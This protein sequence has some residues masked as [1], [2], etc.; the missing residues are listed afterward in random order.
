MEGPVPSR[1]RS[2][3]A[4]LIG[5]RPLA[6][7]AGRL[8]LAL[9]GQARRP[10][11]YLEGGVPDTVEG[12]YELLVLHAWLVI[13]RLAAAGGQGAALAQA[14]FDHMFADIDRALRELGVGDLGVGR[15]VR[16]MAEGFYGR[17]AAYRAA[18]AA[19]PDAADLELALHR[20]LYGGAEPPE[21]A[22][23]AVAA[24]VFGA[25]AALAAQ[26]AAELMAGRLPVLAP[27]KVAASHEEDD[28]TRGIQPA[29]QPRKA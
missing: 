10:S 11:F 22:L 12:R 27:A 6:R 5:R 18:L 20:N 29:F 28:G 1:A 23:P 14:L 3:I 26:P 21:G 13:D 19:G 15:R 4:R 2:L 8:Y 9:A 7:Q 25:A 24:Y 16:R 17:A